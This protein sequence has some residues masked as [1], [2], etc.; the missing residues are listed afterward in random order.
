LNILATVLLVLL[1]I[2]AV[3]ILL[4]TAELRAGLL[5]GWEAAAAIVLMAVG[6]LAIGHF[7]GGPRADQRGA[8][9]TACVARNFGLALFITGL[10]EGGAGSML[11]LV[12]YLLI[13]MALATPYGLWI[14]RQVE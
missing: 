2:V 12:V 1:A 10:S 8:L 5:V 3:A 4:S 9:A 14:R 7:V 13:G 11:T 6:A